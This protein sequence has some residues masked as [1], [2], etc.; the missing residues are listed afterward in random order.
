MKNKKE[1]IFYNPNAFSSKVMEFIEYMVGATYIAWSRKTLGAKSRM[2]PAA[3]GYKLLHALNG[4]ERGGFIKKHGTEQYQLTGKGIKRINVAKV[5]RF[6]FSNFKKDGYW[7][8]VIFDIPE[9]QSFKR[10]LLRQKL[11][12]FNFRLLQKSVFV[13]P[14]VCEKE[15]RELCQYLNLENEVCVVI[16]KNLGVFEKRFKTYFD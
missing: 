12:E 2:D 6:S 8:V 11:K 3:H 1:V 14:Y 13:S 7:R 4:L 10:N 5:W 9:E 16:A 15:I